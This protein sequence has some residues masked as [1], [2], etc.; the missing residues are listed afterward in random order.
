MSAYPE[1]SSTITLQRSRSLDG[2]EFGPLGR[3][4]RWAAGHVRAVAL[5]WVAV[6]VLLG[7]FAP[8][9]EKALSGASEGVTRMKHA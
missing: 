5:A 2:V 7:A 8:R 9:A 1:A 4:G 6:A 3:L